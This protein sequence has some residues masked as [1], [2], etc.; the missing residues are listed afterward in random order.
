MENWSAIHREQTSLSLERT[1]ETIAVYSDT[2]ARARS[3]RWRRAARRGAAGSKGHARYSRLSQVLDP[4]RRGALIKAACAHR[5]QWLA[6]A[7]NLPSTPDMKVIVSVTFTLR[8][9]FASFIYALHT[10]CRMSKIKKNI[11]MIPF[12]LQFMKLTKHKL[13]HIFVFFNKFFLSFLILFWY[14][15]SFVSR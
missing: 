1:R 5:R 15:S 7:P 14:F 4:R 3:E 13:S 2:R 12:V 9:P 6:A 8:Y 11:T 10:W